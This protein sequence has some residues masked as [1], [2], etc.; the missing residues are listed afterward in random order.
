MA[1]DKPD[2]RFGMELVDLTEEFQSALSKFFEPP[3]M[4]V[5]S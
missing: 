2:R 4:Q 3:L 5:A 1:G